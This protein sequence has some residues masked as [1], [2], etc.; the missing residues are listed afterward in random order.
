VLKSETIAAML[1]RIIS[2]FF[3]AAL[4]R[5]FVWATDQ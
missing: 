2:T 3:L 1:P 5:E 4:Q